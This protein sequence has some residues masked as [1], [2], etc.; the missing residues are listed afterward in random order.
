MEDQDLQAIIDKLQGK[1]EE[2]REALVQHAFTRLR[3]LTAKFAGGYSGVRR[4][5]ETD[6]ILQ[7]ASLRL[8]KSLADVPV[9]NVA[10]FFGLA[11][12]AT[13]IIDQLLWVR[14]MGYS[15]VAG[16][17]RRWPANVQLQAVHVGTH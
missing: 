4:W 7:N 3:L 15:R 12:T 2:L 10:S 9:E 14:P 8:W 13:A 16:S 1:P 5:E 17:P 11:A 6:D